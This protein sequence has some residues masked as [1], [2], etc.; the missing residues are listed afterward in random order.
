MKLKQIY[1]KCLAQGT[2]FI[3]SEG[4]GAV[5]DPLREIDA[6]LDEAE[7][8]GVQI[9]YIFETHFHA[10]F[11]SGHVSLAEKTGAKIVFGPKATTQFEAEVAEDGQ[12]YEIGKLKLKVLHTPGH[13]PE[14]T[15]FL[16]YDEEG[17]EHALFSGDTLFIGDV[18]R[19]DLAVKSDLTQEDLAGMLYDSLRN[20][21]MPLS[22]EV[23]VYPAHGAGSACGK[24]MSSE[25]FDTLGN[26]KKVNYALQPMD[27]QEFISKVTEGLS[28]PP[29]YFPE[30]VR[31]N[32]EGYESTA[33]VLDR[34]E[35]ALSVEDFQK[36]K[37]KGAL[38]L[39]T[40]SPQVFNKA[41]VP[42]S[43]NIGLRGQFASWVGALIL[44]MQQP[45][46]LITEAGDEQEAITRLS[47]VGYDQVVGFLDGGI[48]AWQKTGQ[49]V[50]V[51]KSIPAEILEKELSK[52][53]AVI[54]A[55][56]PSEYQAEHIND[57]QVK[58]YPLDQ[59]HEHELNHEKTYYIHCAGGYRSMIMA[60]I[61]KQKGYSV[62]DV[63]GG[64]KAI[65]ETNIPLTNY[66]CPSTLE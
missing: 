26:Q 66:V 36:A 52:G 9:K 42:G 15:S 41:F 38:I 21:I 1:T 44:D 25:T 40:R 2:Y 12:V 20:K 53:I 32:K 60:S 58:N 47:R 4:V 24:N 57:E 54:D 7:A 13:T 18:G 19:P 23:L 64:F 63:T 17:K 3:A 10:D 31:L 5:I 16:L 61:L 55:R 59:V 50:D 29:Q 34:S 30:N 43:I 48:D 35:H 45:M 33:S 39:D 8:N 14:S 46:V 37:D 62:V 28:T 65:K 6:Y 11:V 51:I 27:K 56:R 22:D 49:A